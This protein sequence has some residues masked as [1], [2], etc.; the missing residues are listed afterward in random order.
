MGRKIPTKVTFLKAMYLCGLAVVWPSQLE[1]L[2][3]KDASTLQDS[4][5]ESRAHSV[6]YAFW[7]SLVLILLFGA[8]GVLIGLVLK[9][10]QGAPSTTTVNVLQMT[11]AGLL[12]W[13]TLFIRGFE[14]QSYSCA[15]LGERV[16]QWL[17][18]AMY[19]IGT[20]VIICSLMW[21]AK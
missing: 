13:G 4:P 8:L 3:K 9:E 6:N 1:V 18:R 19:C 14:I 7:M 10:F 15:T 12:L 5:D 21:A 16:N 17:Y 11:G 2:E 20:T